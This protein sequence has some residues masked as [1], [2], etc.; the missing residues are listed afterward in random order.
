MNNPASSV[1]IY[2]ICTTINT[3]IMADN[4]IY[5]KFESI[6]ERQ[7]DAPAI[8]TEEQ[9]LTY[10]QLNDMANEIMALFYDRHIPRIGLIMR[11][12]PRQIA[13]MLAILKSGAAYVP[14]EPFIP[15]ARTDYMMQTAGVDLI[16][17]DDYCNKAR[18]TGR[19]MPDRSEP[20]APA[21]ILYTSGTSGRPKGVI[22]ENH[23]VTNYTRAFENEFNIGRG[24]I[25]LQYSVC[26]F[27]IFVEEV[28][29]TL[30]NGAALCIP[31]EKKRNGNIRELMEFVEKHGVTIV[32]GFPY[33][34]A[35]MNKLESIPPSIRL[36]ISGGDIVRESYINNL[37][38]KGIIIYNTYGP[39]E[40][41]VCSNYYRI[42]NA[43]ALPDGTF[44]VGKAIK[45]VEVKIL[46][47][48]L[49][50]VPKGT[51][52]EIC[53]FGEGIAQGYTGN[54]P[55]QKNFVSIKNGARFYR[56]GD[57]GYEMDD[58]NIVFLHRRDNQVMI[59]GKRVEPE[60]VENILN[61]CPCV[62]RG[63]VRAFLDENGL[64]YLVA[65]LMPKA[66]C[67]LHEIH[68]W[69]SERL[70][71]FM[72]PEFFVKMKQIPIT[73]RG[74]IDLEMLPVIMKEGAAV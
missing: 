28:F 45:G 32:D 55:E 74:K 61:T 54:P 3:Y 65:Y 69:L 41:T 13:A 7:P 17:T 59:M 50:E 51:V 33:L 49:R 15:K 27:D 57:V 38:D 6:V 8:I 23:S 58:G 43:K 42:D 16:I 53:I 63:I 12:G 30:L 29:A 4:T 67:T 24:D 47:N 39:S 40:T 9:T 44:P 64:Y 5:S 34:L 37:R 36:I 68:K 66:A 25:M 35:E 52:G 60:E 1:I 46:D 10:S 26:S 14:T 72:V 56:S 48:N 2:G 73:R 20:N 31:P 62:D 18:G 22:I 11:H 71:D 70:V 21:Y 19:V